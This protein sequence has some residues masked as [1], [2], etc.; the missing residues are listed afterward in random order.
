MSSDF[1]FT[2]T[3]GFLGNVLVKPY[4]NTQCPSPQ[5]DPTIHNS[6]FTKLKSPQPTLLYFTYHDYG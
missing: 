5:F 1:N 4:F 2:V 6:L 3:S